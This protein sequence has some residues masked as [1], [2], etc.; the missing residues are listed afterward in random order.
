MD[1]ALRCF[2]LG[3]Q[4]RCDYWIAYG[5]LEAAVVAAINGER[6]VSSESKQRARAARA[7]AEV[8]LK[9]CKRVLPEAWIQVRARGRCCECRLA[10]PRRLLHCL[11][12]AASCPFPCDADARDAGQL[13]RDRGA[14]AGAAGRPAQQRRQRQRCLL[15]GHPPLQCSH[16]KHHAR[17]ARRHDGPLRPD[18]R[19]LQQ[20]GRGAEALQPMQAGALL[21]VGR[22]GK[23]ALLLAAWPPRERNEPA[24]RAQDAA[25][26]LA[27]NMLPCLPIM[28]CPLAPFHS[29]A[30]QKAAWKRH[31]LRCF[32]P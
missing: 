13:G 22:R 16:P 15:R 31:K 30:C 27:P 25:A 26:C 7:E 12:T 23:G 10:P 28:P 5:G 2:E 24:W 20:G 29:E 18:V 8:A 6:G 9:R 3:K 1:A 21:Q 14:P 11:L 4:Q 19:P 17:H 32:A